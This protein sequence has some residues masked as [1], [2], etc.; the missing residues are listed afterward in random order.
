MESIWLIDFTPSELFIFNQKM[1]GALAGTLI[2]YSDHSSE[3]LCMVQQ[4]KYRL[5]TFGCFLQTQNFGNA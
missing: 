4:H 5:L 1:K 3:I 2:L